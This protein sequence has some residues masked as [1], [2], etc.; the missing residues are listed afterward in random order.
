[1]FTGIIEEVGQII[2][3]DKDFIEIS[4]EEVLKDTKIGDS[5]CVNGVCQ[6]VISLN[7]NSFTARLSETTKNISTFSSSSI[8]DYV[9]LERALTLN[10]RLGGHIVSGHVEGIA[11]VIRV[12]KLSEFY[13]LYFE[14]PSNL[15]KYVIKKGSIT[16]NGISLT[17]AEIQDN[18]IMVSIIPHTFNNTNLR[19]NPKY[20]NVE[21]DILAKYVEKF[22]STNNNV[23]NTITEEFLKENGF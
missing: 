3:Y 10:T 18:I 6:T 1:M 9:N 16:I 19:N 17:V 11:K 5:I 14:I 7:K 12:E 15:V 22:L 8:G 23:K 4:C 20:I 2:K 21:T 13:N